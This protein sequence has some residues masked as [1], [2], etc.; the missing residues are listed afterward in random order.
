MNENEAS[1]NADT[2]VERQ[3]IVKPHF[4]Y[5]ILTPPQKCVVV[6]DDGVCVCVCV[7]AC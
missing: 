4:Q 3:R 1:L 5:H 2:D 7:C 6:G